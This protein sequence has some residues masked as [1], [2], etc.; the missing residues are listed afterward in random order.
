MLDLAHL[1]HVLSFTLGVIAMLVVYSARKELPGPYIWPYIIVLFCINL[2]SAAHSYESFI[3]IKASLD[4]G[5]VDLDLHLGVLT[6]LLS[7]VRITLA[8]QF[9]HF[10]WRMSNGTW[11]RGYRTLFVILLWALPGAQALSIL[12]PNLFLPAHLPVSMIVGHLVVFAALQLGATRV[13][14]FSRRVEDKHVIRWLQ[15]FF[16][17]WTIF[18]LLVFANRFAGY[19]YLVSLNTQ[20]LVFGFI[21]LVMN[22][23]HVVYANRFFSEYQAQVTK[24]DIH[25]LMLEYGISKREQDIVKL[26]CEGKTNKEIAAALFIT[27]NTVRDHSSNI[28]RKTGVKNRTQLA[29]LFNS[30][31][32][33]QRPPRTPC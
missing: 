5:T 13:L 19:G 3:K 23:L 33:P 30:L 8:Y 31:A 16:W 27:A 17:F 6:V 32:Q 26:I 22:S 11:K 10:T 4:P 9:M 12:V 21:T 15:A 1:L 24:K 28:Y 25:H 20:L 29:N 18:N 14:L 2:V 7:A